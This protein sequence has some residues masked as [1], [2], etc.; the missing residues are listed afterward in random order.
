[1]PDPGRPDDEAVR[2]HA[3]LGGL[4]D[5]ER[6]D[7]PRLVDADRHAQPVALEARPPRGVGL[8]VA[9]VA[10]AEQVD[11]LGGGTERVTRLGL[12]PGVPRREPARGR[13][14]AHGGQ[15]V[16]DAVGGPS[17][18]ADDLERHAAGPRAALEA[19]ADGQAQRRR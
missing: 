15:L 19:L 13:L 2:A 12:V 10:A 17:G 14:G 11:Q 1:M 16:G 4:L 9:H 3:L 8:E 7:G 18:E 5:V 6:D